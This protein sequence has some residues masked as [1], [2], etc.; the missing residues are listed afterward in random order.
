MR[1]KPIDFATFK[2]IQKM[3]LSSFNHWLLDL[4]NT[5]YDDGVKSV[6][7]ADVIE[8]TDEQVLNILVSVDGIQQSQAEEAVKKMFGD[9]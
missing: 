7:N 2:K 9:I 6:S 3:S 1:K 5:V 4:C 8:L